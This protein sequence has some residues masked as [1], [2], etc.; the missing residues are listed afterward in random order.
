MAIP[1]ILSAEAAEIQKGATFVEWDEKERQEQEIRELDPISDMDGTDEESGLT[2]KMANPRVLKRCLQLLNKLKDKFERNGFDSDSDMQILKT[3]YGD[4]KHMTSTLFDRYQKCCD[5]AECSENER[6]KNGSD[7]VEQFESDFLAALIKEI[8]R[9]NQYKKTR[10]SIESHRM[11]LESIR[12]NVPAAPEA[13]R[14]LRYE[15]NLE[16]AV[17]RTLTQLERLQ[18]M[19]LGQPVVPPIKVD[20]SAS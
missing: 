16:R 20:I 6:K 11:M 4:W 8:D 9:L 13:D 18:R 17:D 10:A 14:L 1:S 3:V 7:P 19:R 15:A 2:R 5:A 12:Q